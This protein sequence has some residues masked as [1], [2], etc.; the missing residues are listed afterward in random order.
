MKQ[1]TRLESIDLYRIGKET[2]PDGDVQ[3]TETQIGTYKVVI[4]ELND[5]VSATI[6]GADITKMWDIS[7][8]LKDLEDYLIPKVD[9]QEDNISL[10]FIN[11]E[12][13]RYK[14][15]S[16]KKSGITIERVQ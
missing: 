1:L 2:L 9:N 11:L 5:N 8:P 16:V 12:G 7:S 13:S 3:E 4:Q 10:Y 6:Y 15:R 14:I